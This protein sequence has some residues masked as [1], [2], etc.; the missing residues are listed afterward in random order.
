MQILLLGFVSRLSCLPPL[1][2]SPGPTLS[3]EEGPAEFLCPL[4]PGRESVFEGGPYWL[5]FPP[6]RHLLSFKLASAYPL[7]DTRWFFL[8]DCLW[9]VVRLDGAGVCFNL[10]ASSGLRSLL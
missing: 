3:F 10:G 1:G 7:G 9:V 2:G 6:P 4:V 8:L 5:I